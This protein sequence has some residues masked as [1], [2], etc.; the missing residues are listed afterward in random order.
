MRQCCVSSVSR[1]R[2]RLRPFVGGQ[3]RGYVLKPH[4]CFLAPKYDPNAH[5]QS[6]PSTT[7]NWTFYVLS[8]SL[9]AMLCTIC[10]NITLKSLN[11]PQGYEHAPSFHALR[12]SA[13]DG[14]CSLCSILWDA[15]ESERAQETKRRQELG[16][17]DDD[18]DDD[19]DHN[20][21]FMDYPVR[22]SVD[23]MIN[24]NKQRLA[25]SLRRRPTYHKFR[26]LCTA[27][28]P[29]TLEVCSLQP[30]K[31][32]VGLGL[33]YRGGALLYGEPGIDVFNGGPYSGRR[34][35]SHANSATCFKLIAHW[36]R[37]CI[38]EHKHCR[39]AVCPSRWTDDADTW[40]RSP[41]YISSTSNE[42]ELSSDQ[43]NSLGDDGQVADNIPEPA[44]SD[45]ISDSEE[46]FERPRKRAKVVI[47]PSSPAAGVGSNSNGPS[48]Q[49]RFGPDSAIQQASLK[50]LA[51]ETEEHLKK[52]TS[53][54]NRSPL[55]KGVLSRK[56]FIPRLDPN[57]RGWLDNLDVHELYYRSEDLR[58]LNSTDTIEIS[59]AE[60]Q[61][62]LLPTRYIHVDSNPP[63]LRIASPDERGFYIAL[64]HCWGTSRPL[65]TTTA[66]LP[67]RMFGIPLSK[68]PRTFRDAVLVARELGIE[69]LWIDSLCI[70]QD[71][72]S[73]WE[74]E[75]AR[76]GAVYGNAFLTISAGAAADSEEGLFKKRSVP[77]GPPVEVRCNDSNFESIYV[78]YMP[79]DTPFEVP[80]ATD[81]RAWCYQE[82]ALSP[83]VLVYGREML[84]WLCDSGTDVEHGDVREYDANED[85]DDP[86]LLA[87]RLNFNF[88]PAR[89]NPLDDIP[90]SIASLDHYLYTKNKEERSLDTWAATVTAFTKR[91]LTHDSDRLPALS[92]IARELH[93][94]GTDDEYLAGLWRRDLFERGILWEVDVF[95]APKGATWRRPAK[96]RAPSWSW[97]S[98]EG[99]IQMALRRGPKDR[100]WEG[101][102]KKHAP[103]LLEAKMV[104]PGQNPYGEVTGGYLKIATYMWSVVLGPFQNKDHINPKYHL[105]PDRWQ[106][107]R[108]LERMR[109]V[110]M[111]TP[112]TE[113]K[114]R[115]GRCSI[116]MPGEKEWDTMELWW[117]EL[118]DA[119]AYGS[120][121]LV[122]RA[123]VGDAFVRVGTACIEKE[124]PT[125][126]NSEYARFPE[127]QILELVLV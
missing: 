122:A 102:E 79:I 126:G 112:D 4:K 12:E 73:D 23:G 19:D 99:P 92:G 22:L 83:R 48:P 117:V 63:Q 32:Q 106:D 123:D 94:R 116:D 16:E 82:M 104:T 127:T 11:R 75:S 56:E 44:L 108:L 39:R 15:V 45:D 95:S 35:S 113:G 80:Q 5:R 9:T 119:Y 10:D 1:R 120:G 40:A 78:D 91:N 6:K 107:K 114:R 33:C 74:I 50:L 96:Y 21:Q 66:T 124:N 31:F 70:L 121:L 26:D 38:T 7:S 25:R 24:E 51:D 87:P 110:Y 103:R 88:L 93:L 55:S 81:S 53:L 68:M 13:E 59:S 46:E 52:V 65:T 29:A 101:L 8:Q 42:S 20:V 30:D 111:Y 62:P 109:E 100:G 105:R 61:A 2:R 86:P 37:T 18:D 43:T 3:N 41:S 36:I 125:H 90:P 77:P 84:G 34:I 49:P 14:L 64:S 17:A 98:I 47:R 118:G 58:R 89:P 67:N 85:D 27:K 76:M 60:P 71:S 115:M 69:Y 97:A 57:G 72:G 54:T 28:K